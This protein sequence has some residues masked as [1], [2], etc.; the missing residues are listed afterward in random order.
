MEQAPGVPT[1]TATAACTPCSLGIHSC[2]STRIRPCDCTAQWHAGQ[3]HAAAVPGS[4]PEHR[5]SL[6]QPQL[7]REA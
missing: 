2:C 7:L 3:S 1:I 6:P 5:G 4:G